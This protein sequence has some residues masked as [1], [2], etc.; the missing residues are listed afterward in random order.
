MNG[1]R[2]DVFINNIFDKLCEIIR[3]KHPQLDIANATIANQINS[4]KSLSTSH[5]VQT[6]MN[7]VN[8]LVDSDTSMQI[9]YQ[10]QD[11][12]QSDLN[13]TNSKSVIEES[14]FCPYCD[15]EVTVE[16]IYCMEC[17]SWLHYECVNLNPETVTNAFRDTEYVCD[18]CNEDVLYG[19][20]QR[21]TQHNTQDAPTSESGDIH[22]VS[23]RDSPLVSRDRSICKDGNIPIAMSDTGTSPKIPFIS[24]D[25]N[26]SSSGSHAASHDIPPEFNGQIVST[27][28]SAHI[29][30][31]KQTQKAD[32]LSQSPKPRKPPNKKPK[33]DKAINDSTILLAQKTRILD[34]ENEI[35]QLKNAFESVKAHV[36]QTVSSTA[37]PEPHRSHSNVCSTPQTET[38]ILQQ[39][40]HEQLEGRLRMLEHQVVQNMCISTAVNT[41][42]A[43]QVNLNRQYNNQKPPNMTDR[44]THIPVPTYNQPVF[45]GGYGYPPHIGAPSV[46]PPSYPYATQ[47][48]ASAPIHILHPQHIISHNPYNTQVYGMS[49]PLRYVNNIVQP[50]CHPMR[51]MTDPAL[52]FG[53]S[54]PP[55]APT[56]TLHGQPFINQMSNTMHHVPQNNNPGVPHPPRAPTAIPH[57]QLHASSVSSVN[58]TQS[59]TNKGAPS[60]SYDS[61]NTPLHG[62]NSPV[63]AETQHLEQSTPVQDTEIILIPSTPVRTPS[64]SIEDR[65]E[66]PHTPVCGPAGECSDKYSKRSIV[67]PHNPQQVDMLNIE[68]ERLDS[69]AKQDGNNQGD[70]SHFRIPSLQK[71]PPDCPNLMEEI[72]NLSKRP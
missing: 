49:G 71:V 28:T 40:R 60:I 5:T 10:A 42:L 19:D 66:K 25:S 12:Q 67:S 53:I 23:E 48:S 16:G 54:H 17:E 26:R 64:I 55:R 56:S 33:P 50:V 46:P 63:H 57:K 15:Q 3:N 2:V 29:S 35:K 59:S 6:T 38:H 1:S 51:A 18:Q 65:S 11:S 44:P 41:Q 24:I 61:L 39:I 36:P 70:H 32:A 72:Q 34:L 47:Q 20:S 14:A 9:E 22:T 7:N 58:A 13:S 43:L 4:L 31:D 68:G 27:V 37:S 69:I 8:T 45:H 52:L 62:A 30:T 21:S